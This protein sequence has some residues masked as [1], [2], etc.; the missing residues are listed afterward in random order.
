LVL[1]ILVIKLPKGLLRF[2]QEE[3]FWD[4]ERQKERGENPDGQGFETEISLPYFMEI[5][6]SLTA[7][8]DER[9]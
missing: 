2:W 6:L 9:D 8:A 1:A 7:R 4:G 3:F 5:L